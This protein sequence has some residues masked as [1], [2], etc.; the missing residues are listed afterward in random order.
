MNAAIPTKYAG[1]QF[2]S[3]LEAR[4]AAFF[5]LLGFGWEYEPLDLDGYIP[6]F[7]LC[8][9]VLVE[10]KP[11]MWT[12]SVEDL[13]VVEA[14]RIKIE[15]AN[16]G[17]FHWIALLGATLPAGEGALGDVAFADPTDATLPWAWRPLTA[18]WWPSN[19]E[20]SLLGQ[21]LLRSHLHTAAPPPDGL[22]AEAG[23]RVQWRAR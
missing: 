14:A 17:R 6:D 20:F 13:A 2:R 1:V 5:D 12:R 22:W 16:A 19:S 4:W 10:V 9:H 23:N 15:H 7:V 3:R 21:P 18:G 8:R 11:V